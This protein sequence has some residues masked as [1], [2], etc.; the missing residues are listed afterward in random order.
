MRRTIVF[1]AFVAVVVSGNAY[2]GGAK[3][4][5]VAPKAGQVATI[6]IDES[7]DGTLTSGKSSEPIAEKEH[8]SFSEE[9]VTVDGVTVTK[10]KVV[11][12]DDVRDG[13]DQPSKGKTYVVSSSGGAATVTGADGKDA[14]EPEKFAAAR[15]ASEVGK[16]DKL[17]A[18]VGQKTFAKGQKVALTADDAAVLFSLGEDLTVKKMTIALKSQDAT[19]ATFALTGQMGGPQAGYDFTADVT[20]TLRVELATGRPLDFALKGAMTGGGAA[21]GQKITMKGKLAVHKAWTYK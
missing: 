7:I 19:S 11:V 4:T 9:V 15:L 18:L 17:L 8:S 20:A 14:A 16:P 1:G 13:H 12:T 21:D 5:Q 2:A 6:V 3:V 10:A